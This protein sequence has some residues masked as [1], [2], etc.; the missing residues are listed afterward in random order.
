MVPAVGTNEGA[1]RQH[2]SPP[3][4][5]SQEHV[6]PERHHERDQHRVG[7]EPGDT[8]HDPCRPRDSMVHD[9]PRD[10]RIGEDRLLARDHILGEPD[11]DPD[12][13]RAGDHD[14]TQQEASG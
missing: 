2:P 7:P 9:E 13:D 4:L 8:L 10:V 14:D 12:A 6:A 1:D 5:L 3:V 11:E